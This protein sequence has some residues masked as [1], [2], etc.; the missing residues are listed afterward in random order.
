MLYTLPTFLSGGDYLALV[1]SLFEQWDSTDALPG[2]LKRLIKQY[3]EKAIADP[4]GYSEQSTR[5]LKRFSLN[6]LSE[7]IDMSETIKLDSEALAKL[8]K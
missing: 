1:R 6:S 7:L 8:F 2:L 4:A 5:W 3:G